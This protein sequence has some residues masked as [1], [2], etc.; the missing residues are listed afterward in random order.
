[1]QIYASETNGVKTVRA[2]FFCSQSQIS[3]FQRFPNVIELD[4]T[5]M[6]LCDSCKDSSYLF[7]SYQ[8]LAI[9]NHAY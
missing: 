3:L 1:M 7:I 9:F 5:R 8:L 4:D 2:L 6:S